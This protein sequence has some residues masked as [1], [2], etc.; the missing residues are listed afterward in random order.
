M[1]GDT[2]FT[3]EVESMNT[4]RIG[5]KIIGD[6]NECFVIAEAGVN[7]NGSVE[8]AKQLIDAAK[9][10]NVNAIKFQTFK[11]EKL[12][13]R[14]AEKA[15]YQKETTDEG[16]QYEML[17]KLELSEDEFI[18]L[19]NYARKQELLF[20]ST[21]FDNE[22]AD[23][24]EKIGV[25]AY[26]VG[27]GDLTNIPLLEH[28]ARK[29]KPI[30]LSTGM[31][32]LEEVETAFNSITNTGNEEIILLHCITSYPTPI[33]EVNLR[34]IQTLRQKFQV[35]IGFS[36]HTIGLIAP[37][38]AVSLGAS[39]L[40]K[41]FTLDKNLPGPDHRVS[42]NPEELQEM[43]KVIKQTTSALGD[44]IK[45]PVGVE[46]D[47][48]RIARRSIIAKLDIQKG[49]IIKAD[50]LDIKRPAI[51]IEPKFFEEILGKKVKR[52]ISEDEPLTWDML[53]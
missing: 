43:V 28:I 41:H 49:Q 25:P 4:V 33:E 34:A 1:I 30:I 35:P 8:T 16:S 38:I 37:I 42:L 12:V 47:I 36:D 52:P 51:G 15:Q 14:T 20:L 50:M 2:S 46:I 29:N 17:Q 6:D 23:L 24:L 39:I 5:K 21:P 10:C 3:I 19:A 18:E 13:T 9:G 11:T 26:K 45:R 31:G 44:G 27:S 40:E 48:K 32:T 7:H 22:S 53:E